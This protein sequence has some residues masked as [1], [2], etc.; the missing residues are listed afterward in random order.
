MP[1]QSYPHTMI[2]VVAR[3]SEER[4]TV[5][6]GT[7]RYDILFEKIILSRNIA[8]EAKENDQLDN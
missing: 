3:L 2:H 6:S 4:A 5:R 1:V 8:D 7:D